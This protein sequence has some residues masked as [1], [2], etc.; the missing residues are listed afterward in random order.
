MKL[1]KAIAII[2][3]IFGSE[4]NE[5]L[6]EI[7]REAI[8]QEIDIHKLSSPIN[9]IEIKKES[10]IPKEWNNA[11]PYGNIEWVTGKGKSC[12]KIFRE[13]KK[14]KVVKKINFKGDNYD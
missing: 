4:S 14:K 8:Y 1:Y 9:I 12:R 6:G 13:L 7:A 10:D 11:I 5:N 2:D 3:V